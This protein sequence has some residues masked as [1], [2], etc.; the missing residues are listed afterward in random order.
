MDG[1]QSSNG[2]IIILTTN[3]PEKIDSALLRPGRIDINIR[4]GELSVELIYT[5]ATTGILNK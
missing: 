5:C 3:H 2:R 4:L 1:I